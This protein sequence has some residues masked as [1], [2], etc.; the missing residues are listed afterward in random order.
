[1]K[2]ILIIYLS[3]TKLID[4]YSSIINYDKI[5]VLSNVKNIENFSSFDNKKFI[6]IGLKTVEN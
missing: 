2:N 3:K 6:F 5:Y 4:I 1:M